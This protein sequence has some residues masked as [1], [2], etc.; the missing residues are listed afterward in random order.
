MSSKPVT[1][2]WMVSS[3][4]LISLL[5][6]R[7]S[8]SFVSMSAF[9]LFRSALHQSLFCSSDSCSFSIKSSI[10]SISANTMSKGLPSLRSC[11]ALSKCLEPLTARL[12][13]FSTS[14]RLPEM[15]LLLLPVCKNSGKVSPVLVAS[16]L[17][18]VVNAASLLRMAIASAIAASSWV[19]RAKRS[20]YCL[21]F[22]AH[23]GNNSAKKASSLALLS[24]AL[25]RCSF[26]AVSSA[27]LAAN[28]PC[29]LS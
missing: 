4:S 24:L 12:R 25:L 23:M 19:R 17:P 6:P 1:G 7:I 10:F 11:I 2:K 20:W 14:K 27:S 8:E 26:C 13:N 9:V 16:T 15:D 18:K 21:A 3:R 5:R 29:F 28:S 22:S